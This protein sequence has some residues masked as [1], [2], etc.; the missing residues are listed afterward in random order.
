ML[1]VVILKSVLLHVAGEHTPGGAIRE[2][3]MQPPNRCTGTSNLGPKQAQRDGG[4]APSLHFIFSLSLLLPVNCIGVS[5][6]LF[7][8]CGLQE[9]NQTS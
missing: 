6:S 3:E 7:F 4:N 9:S 1:A 8:M 5:L 2:P